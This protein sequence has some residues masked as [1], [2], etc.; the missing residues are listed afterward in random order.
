MADGRE[1]KTVLFSQLLTAISLSSVSSSQ[2][3][4]ALLSSPPIKVKK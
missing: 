1:G 3:V 2:P 4:A